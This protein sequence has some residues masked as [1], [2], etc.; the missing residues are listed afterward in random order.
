MKY[1]GLTYDIINAAF[2]VYNEMGFGFLEKVYENCMIEILSENSL[3]VQSQCSIT[4]MFHKTQVGSYTA[5][6]LV[7]GK[8]LVEL[9]TCNAIAKEH[10]HQLYNYL[11]ATGLEVGLI[12]NFAPH[13]LEYRR[14]TRKKAEPKDPTLKSEQSE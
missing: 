2:E 1:N 6:L 9:K 8:I 12:L 14:V 7:N 11:K 10:R 4:V 5:D 3:N 13:S